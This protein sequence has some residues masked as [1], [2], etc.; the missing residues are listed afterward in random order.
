MII[1]WKGN[2]FYDKPTDGFVGGLEGDTE[3]D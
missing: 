3:I 1:C 2:A